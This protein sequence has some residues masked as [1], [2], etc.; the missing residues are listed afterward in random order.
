MGDVITHHCGN[1]YTCLN[2]LHQECCDKAGLINKK[3]DTCFCSSDCEKL[4][5]MA[6]SNQLPTNDAWKIISPQTM[7]KVKHLFLKLNGLQDSMAADKVVKFT[8]MV[9]VKKRGKPIQSFIDRLPAGKF[10][11]RAI[12]A[13][14]SH[15]PDKIKPKLYQCLEYLW[16]PRSETL[17]PDANQESPDK[18]SETKPP[19]QAMSGDPSNNDDD[20]GAGG[21]A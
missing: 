13:I 11:P 19:N 6:T 15:A 7:T 14:R 17:M 2:A 4:F 16:P 18:E 8:L 5:Q 20:E 10:Y 21:T 12:T 9:H 1:T 3:T